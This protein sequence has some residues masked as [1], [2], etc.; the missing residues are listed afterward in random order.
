[1]SPERNRQQQKDVPT[2][3]DLDR[4]DAT[5]SACANATEDFIEFTQGSSSEEFKTLGEKF[6]YDGMTTNRF[7]LR[8][9]DL[10]YRND[11]PPI[12]AWQTAYGIEVQT[13]GQGMKVALN[14]VLLYKEGLF[15][16]IDAEELD[17]LNAETGLEDPMTAEEIEEF[18][19]KTITE[20]PQALFYFLDVFPEEAKNVSLTN[21]NY[22]FAT[23][24]A[25][26]MAEG[27]FPVDKGYPGTPEFKAHLTEGIQL[28]KR[29][30]STLDEEGLDQLPTEARRLKDM[31]DDAINDFSQ[32]FLINRVVVCK[33]QGLLDPWD[34]EKR[35]MQPT[36][37]ELIRN[38]K[39]YLDCD[40]RNLPLN[41]GE[42]GAATPP[43][44]PWRE[45]TTNHWDKNHQLFGR[46][47]ALSLDGTLQVDYKLD[48]THFPSQYGFFSDIEITDIKDG[49]VRQRI[50]L[51]QEAIGG[52]IPVAVIIGGNFDF[53]DPRVNPY[54][55]IL[56]G[57]E[58]AKKDV[59]NVVKDV[60]Q[61][62]QEGKLHT[63]EGLYRSVKDM[64]ESS[65]EES[66]S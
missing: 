64:E 2:K 12:S 21:A 52:L 58:K 65:D 56:A 23:H 8:W 10:S 5:K 40:A 60:I 37:E 25:V 33:G 50:V 9:G 54:L 49:Q 31:D 11:Q 35:K 48:S 66:E 28:V 16:E 62:Q 22:L 15:D 18:K 26:G 61:M 53:S 44:E 3:A 38:G 30:V 17:E 57:D 47:E 34:S 36:P 4:V 59:R 43:N 45:F 46:Y 14:G 20:G 39:S 63:V 19:Q 7:V 1:M 24:M 51:S 13:F 42:I 27:K 32:S 29:Y 41:K 55:R 6:V